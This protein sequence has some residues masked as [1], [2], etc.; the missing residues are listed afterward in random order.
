MAESKVDRF[1]MFLLPALHITEDVIGLDREQHLVVCGF[2]GIRSR[3]V[4]L[5]V[6]VVLVYLN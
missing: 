2:G 6:V 4:Q 5:D 1:H 3:S